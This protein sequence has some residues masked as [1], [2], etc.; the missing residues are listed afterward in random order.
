MAKQKRP[1]FKQKPILYFDENFPV[2]AMEHFRTN[3][4]WKKK[5]KVQS[6]V[7]DGNNGQ[8]DKFHFGY[9]KRNA[10]TLVA[11][12]GDF[13][14]DR[15]YPFAYGDMPGVI[16]IKETKSQVRRIVVVLSSVLDFVL[17]APFP[18]GFLLESKF[19]ASGEGCVMRGR[20]ARTKGN[21]IDA[22]SSPDK[23]KIVTGAVFFILKSHQARAKR[24][25]EPRLLVY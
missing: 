8:P 19:I 2:S 9:C 5:V 11:L 14:D 16:M 17:L 25:P 4:Y 21:K 22:T 20:D 15:V 13:N 6:A 1:F 18:K 12:D 3:S 10:Y 7:E 23:Q 24:R